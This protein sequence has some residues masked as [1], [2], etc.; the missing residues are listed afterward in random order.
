MKKHGIQISYNTGNIKFIL[1][2]VTP[3]NN[4]YASRALLL[5]VRMC[6]YSRLS[7]NNQGSGL[8]G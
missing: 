6:D 5:Y 4:N 8:Q 3:Q 2:D 7:K 1:F